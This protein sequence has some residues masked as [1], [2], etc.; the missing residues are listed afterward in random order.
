M[1]LKPCLWKRFIKEQSEDV[2][3]TFGIIGAA[4]VGIQTLEHLIGIALLYVY[5]VENCLPQVNQG[6]PFLSMG[7]C[8]FPKGVSI[9]VETSKAPA[10]SRFKCALSTTSAIR[11]CAPKA[12]SVFAL[13]RGRRLSVMVR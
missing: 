7:I 3:L 10:D 4:L 11:S 6:F 1:S 9:A 2:Q 8:L 5:R 12:S 13:A